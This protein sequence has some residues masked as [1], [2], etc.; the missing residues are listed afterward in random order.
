VLV[1]VL[2]VYRCTML[3][4][5]LRML[6]PAPLA[7]LVVHPLVVFVIP[8]RLSA[9]V[10]GGVRVRNVAPGRYF[11]LRHHTHYEPSFAELN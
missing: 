7:V 9:G 4:L 6:P 5:P 8:P 3:L 10:Q 1:L 2:M 11:S